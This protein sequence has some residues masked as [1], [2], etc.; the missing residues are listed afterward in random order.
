[1]RRVLRYRDSQLF[2]LG[3]VLSVIGLF[4]IFDAGYP[5]SIQAGRGAVPREFWMQ[6]VCLAIGL[7]AAAMVS[8]LHWKDWLKASKFVWMLAFGLLVAVAIPGVG[9]EMNGA[10]R[11]LRLG[12]F[13]LQP[14][15]FAKVALVLYLAGV[16][17]VRKP[18][19]SQKGRPMG[20]ALWLDNVA[21][22]KVKRWLPGVWALIAVAL[23]ALEPDLGTAAVLAVTAF[24]MFVV[25]GATTKSLLF[26]AAVGAVGVFALVLAEPYR[27]ERIL[28]HYHRYEQSR[29]DDIGYQTVQSELSMAS[30]GLIGVGVGAGRAKHVLPAATTDFVSTTLAEEAGFLGWL[31]VVSL[32]LALTV[33]LFVLAKRAPSRFSSLVLAGV[34]SWIGLQSI[35]NLLMANGT[36]PAIG[37]P[38]PFLSYGGSSLIALWIAMGVCQ[39]ALAP[40]PIPKEERFAPGDHRW[41]HRRPR[42]SRA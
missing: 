20:I 36:L 37:I 33:R 17:A 24:A 28:N 34:G 38:L 11:W 35:T 13:L 7:A 23:I 26:G 39:A 12:P 1:M 5:R 30:G 4:L 42:L 16:L 8:R 40:K 10:V 9:V 19:R 32:L 27:M 2:V 21:V 6:S 41:R 15:E 29:I 14:S 22:P 25:G 18:R 31:A 3:L